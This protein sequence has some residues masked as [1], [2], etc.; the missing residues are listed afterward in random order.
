MIFTPRRFCP[1]SPPDVCV[2]R[3]RTTCRA[4]ASTMIL[5]P[6]L[7]HGTGR[8]LLSLR[9]PVTQRSSMIAAFGPADAAV[10]CPPPSVSTTCAPTTPAGRPARQP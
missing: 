10:Q 6:L 5:H 7:P 9:G 1:Q 8:T 2:E 4:S 3:R